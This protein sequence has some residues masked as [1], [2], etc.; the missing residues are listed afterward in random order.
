[1]TLLESD[2]NIEHYLGALE[3]SI[4]LSDAAAQKRLGEHA[5]VTLV[6]IDNA[7]KYLDEDVY[8]EVELIRT[9]IDELRVQYA[10]GKM[11]GAEKLEEIEERIEHGYQKLKN[12]VRKTKKL[13]EHEREELNEALHK[14]WRS[15]KLEIN[16][17]HLRLSLAHDTGSEK[18]A[19]AKKELVKDA[20]HIAKLG[21]KEAELIGE[22]FSPWC[23]KIKKSVSKSALKV[24]R[25]MEKYLLDS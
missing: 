1:M 17:L 5:A 13:T 8:H 2:K 25:S 23:E 14:G 16:L 15:L 10:L 18:L 11:E 12:A 22:N 7:Q 19:A 3:T 21:K 6:H 4:I 20:K 9:A 24:I